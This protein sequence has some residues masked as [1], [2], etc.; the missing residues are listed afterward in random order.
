MTN[1]VFLIF[2][3]AFLASIVVIDLYKIRKKVEKIENLLARNIDTV[4]RLQI[5]NFLNKKR[6][7]NAA[8]R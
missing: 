5:E 7:T 2:C 6:T 8:T 1:E 4:N 3:L